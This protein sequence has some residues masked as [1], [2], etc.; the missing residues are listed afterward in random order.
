MVS[1]IKLALLPTSA[2]TAYLLLPL[3]EVLMALAPP[4]LALAA[5]DDTALAQ[6]RSTPDR[7]TDMATEGR[8]GSAVQRGKELTAAVTRVYYVRTYVLQVLQEQARDMQHRA[9][10]EDEGEGCQEEGR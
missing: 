6:G 8:K 9:M 3:F 4:A 10:M 7:S 1:L 2:L 5:A